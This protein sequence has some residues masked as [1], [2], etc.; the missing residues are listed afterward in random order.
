[1]FTTILQSLQIQFNTVVIILINH[2][3]FNYLEN[4]YLLMLVDGYFPFHYSN[5]NNNYGFTRI[6]VNHWL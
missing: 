1:M 4:S 6:C 3:T 2:T 5:F